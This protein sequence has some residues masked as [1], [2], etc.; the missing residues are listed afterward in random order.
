[1]GAGEL[2][3]LY[4]SDCS[5]SVSGAA[6][7]SPDA[8]SLLLS[9]GCARTRVCLW[10]LWWWLCLWWWWCGLN[11]DVQASNRR[12][13]QRPCGV[14]RS[15]T[16]ATNARLLGFWDCTP[17]FRFASIETV[18]T[19]HF[20]LFHIRMQLIR[21]IT[22]YIHHT[23]EWLRSLPAN[24]EKGEFFFFYFFIKSCFLCYSL[25]KKKYFRNTE[26]GKLHLGAD[27]DK[28]SDR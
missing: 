8:F 18:S 19:L 26:F 4:I 15:L 10:G 7:P 28:V 9:R 21:N 20:C 13:I 5:L 24:T 3:L 27:N 2:S 16:K 6:S 23:R 11:A 25:R 1:M 12:Q 22:V 17:G 14:L